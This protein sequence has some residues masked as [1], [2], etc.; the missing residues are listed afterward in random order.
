ME[1]INS[2]E[3][4]IFYWINQHHSTFFDWFFWS[5]SQQWCWAVMLILFFCIT[6]LRYEPKRWW[7]ILIGIVL[8]FLCADRVSDI[9]KDVFTR[10]RPCYAL[11]NV[12]MFR[13]HCGGQYGFP[14]SHAANVFALATFLCLRCHQSAIRLQRATRS[15]RPK[16]AIHPS[17]FTFFVF[18]WAIVV[19][20]SRI[21]LGKHYL[22]D[23]L[24]GLILGML[25]GLFIF[26]DR[27]STV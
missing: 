20:Y 4:N 3:T 5:F 2:L 6:T 17:L 21:Y 7:L 10:L 12:R 11:D 13:T 27:K 26:L 15:P 16:Y 22:G 24:G 1:M 8:C 19:G 9:L 14:S 23:I 25:I 18:L